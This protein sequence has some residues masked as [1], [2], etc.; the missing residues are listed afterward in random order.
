MALLKRW[1]RR[2]GRKLPAVFAAFAVTAATS[3]VHTALLPPAGAQSGAPGTPGAGGAPSAG[4][5][6]GGATPGGANPAPKA[7]F[8]QVLAWLSEAR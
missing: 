5:T 7:S 2:L 3:L 6:P 4:A 1:R 8:D